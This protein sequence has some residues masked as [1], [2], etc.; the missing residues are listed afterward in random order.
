MVDPDIP[1]RLPQHSIASALGMEPTEEEI[2]TTMKTM[3]NT[4]VVG[5]DGLPAELLKLGLQQDPTILLELHRLT[6]LLWREGKVPQQLKD[7]VIIVLHNKGDKTECGNYRGISLASHVG[8][9]QET[10]RLLLRRRDCYLRSSAVSTGSID[11]GHDICGSQA[12]GNWMEGRRVSLHVL[13]RSPEGLR[14][15]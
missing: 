9:I 12:A 7:T 6:T 5:P 8:K 4:K 3:A 1:K 2:A 10:Q 13:H 11:H 15:R 14:H